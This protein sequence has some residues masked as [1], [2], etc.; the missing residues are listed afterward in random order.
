M[1]SRFR[2]FRT[3]IY[4]KLDRIEIIV[5]ACC[6]LHNYL[7]RRCT[8]FEEE[9]SSVGEFEGDENV[10]IPL[11]K[12]FSRHYDQQGRVVRD[13]Y[14]SVLQSRRKSRMEKQNDQLVLIRNPINLYLFLNECYCF[15]TIPY[16]H[17]VLFL[18]S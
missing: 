15:I 16:Y 13:M 3:E 7:R 18:K 10:F 17:I 9:E 4:L 12:G 6:V 8:S 1:A 11:Q 14:F 5:M 2:I